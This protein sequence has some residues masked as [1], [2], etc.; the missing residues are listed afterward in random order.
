[1]KTPDSSLGLTPLWRLELPVA[2]ERLCRSKRI[3][4]VEQAYD[5]VCAL[6]V[7]TWPVVYAGTLSPGELDAARKALAAA[8][9]GMMERS[10]VLPMDSHPLAG[11]LPPGDRAP[12]E[13]F[14]AERDLMDLMASPEEEGG[15]A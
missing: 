3:V 15:T 13:R 7:N 5:L 10:P 14:E 2:F 8:L 1:M 11:V 4:T 6:R 9:P 12:P